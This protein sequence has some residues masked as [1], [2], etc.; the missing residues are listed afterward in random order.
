MN[1]DITALI[2][3]LFGGGTLGAITASLVTRRRDRE[4][5][6]ID[7]DDAAVKRLKDATDILLRVID[8]ERRDRRAQIREE[9]KEMERRITAAI[10]RS[11]EDCAE[12]MVQLKREL[13]KQFEER[14]KEVQSG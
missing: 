3:A 5:H 1:L 12:S 13:E 8:T 9:Q 11:E 2:V 14:L 4:R 10:E 6:E 7:T